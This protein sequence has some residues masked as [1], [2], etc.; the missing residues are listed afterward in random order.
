MFFFL[1]KCTFFLLQ[2]EGRELQ[3]GWSAGRLL[4]D[5]LNSKVKRF[6]LNFLSLFKYF[7]SLSNMIQVQIT[8][9]TTNVEIVLSTIRNVYYLVMIRTI[10]HIYIV[11]KVYF[12]YQNSSFQKVKKIWTV[13]KYYWLRSSFEQDRGI[14]LSQ[15][16]P[17][18]SLWNKVVYG[19]NQNKHSR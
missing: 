12:V 8:L 5:K 14:I 18:W 6:F 4:S 10:L 11:K 17:F 7:K 16:K 15:R 13:I 19:Q 9:K 3:C 2:L 1:F